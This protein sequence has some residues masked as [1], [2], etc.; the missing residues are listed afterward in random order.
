MID[1]IEIRAKR[2]KVFES[3]LLTNISGN[4]PDEVIDTTRQGFVVAA[5]DGAIIIK[6]VQVEGSP[7]IEASEFTKQVGLKVGDRLG[8]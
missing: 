6:R 2:F 3:E 7:K 1:Q 8:Q 5:M 4:L